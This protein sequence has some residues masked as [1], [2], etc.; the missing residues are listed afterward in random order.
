MKLL[1]GIPAYNEGRMISDVIK[2]IPAKIDGCKTVEVLVLDD[3]ST[4]KTRTIAQKCGVI[5]LSHMINRGLGGALKTIFAFAKQEHYD[6][7]V[8]FDADGQHNSSDIRHLIKPIIDNHKD[9]VIGTRWVKRTNVPISRLF[10]N[11][12]A[13]IATYFLFGVWTSDSQ[14]GFRAFSKKAIQKINIQTDGMEVSSEL[15]REIYRNKL[16][17]S[18]IPI[19][20]L[21]TDYSESKGQR[22]DNAPNVFF[23]LLFRLLK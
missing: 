15:F 18:E 8:T 9:V 1:I 6:V 11:Q 5:V 7:L 12:I 16:K 10:I 23:Q 3:G 21:Y 19:N 14:S 20:A 13:N 22:L 4:D 17:Y 2:S